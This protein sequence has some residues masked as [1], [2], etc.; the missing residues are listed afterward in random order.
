MA[1]T[2]DALQ[3]LGP[4]RR[5]AIICGASSW[6]NLPQFA[7][8]DA[9]SNSATAMGEYMESPEGMQVP[10]ANVLWLFDANNAG[11]QYDRI[12][13]F[14]QDGL[15]RIEQPNG[16]GVLIMLFYVGHG[17]FF[18]KDEEYCLLVR[19]TRNPLPDE[20]SLK[21]TS[22]SRLLKNAAPQSSRLFIL[23]CCF[24]GAAAG[25]VHQSAIEQIA[26]QRAKEQTILDRSIA[27][28]CAA[29]SRNTAKVAP[30]G[31][32]TSF[33]RALMHALAMGDDRSSNRQFLTLHEVC[34]LTRNALDDLDDDAAAR[35]EVHSPD[36]EMLDLAQQRLFRN[37]A[38]TSAPVSAPPPRHVVT[39]VASV[40]NL[41]N[42]MNENSI[43]TTRW[44]WMPWSLKRSQMDYYMSLIT[45]Y[46]VAL[47]NLPTIISVLG[48]S[49]GDPSTV[50][51]LVV[52][53]LAY[54]IGRENTTR[55]FY[56]E[57]SPGSTLQLIP[58]Y[59]AGRVGIS[60]PKEINDETEQ[61]ASIIEAVL[62][63]KILFIHNA[64]LYE[65]GYW[66]E[67]QRDFAC[68]VAVPVAAGNVVFGALIAD[69]PVVGDFT[70]GD[71]GVA[72]VLAGLLAIS[73]KQRL[74][75]SSSSRSGEAEET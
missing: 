41:T 68:M 44:S 12:A 8:S 42:S 29:S 48:E 6:I 5:F 62:D 49:E 19:D 74:L 15:K 28:L 43:P 59:S 69:A 30:S 57:L 58:T 36:Q 72:N 50:A 51:L 47:E 17:A 66:G 64:E 40:R 3:S 25:R 34:E 54:L 45:K 27:L 75:E 61:G 71:I 31:E 26:Q 63:N 23:D 52:N 24:A 33:T 73:M 13:S 1:I 38:F 4:E 7:D 35:P 60:G 20:T 18:T 70:P 16:L 22:L 46:Q 55:V 67:H 14:L 11:D 37:K 32:K 2:A 9:F 65:S 39:D 56:F 10:K 21:V 53:S